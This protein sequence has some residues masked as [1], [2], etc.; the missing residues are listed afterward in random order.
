[1]DTIT[2]TDQTP[3]G[4][5]VTGEGPPLVLVHGGTAD[6]TRWRNTLSLLEPHATV[7]AIDRR[8]R[9]SSGDSHDYSLEKEFADVAAVV[10]QASARAGGPVGLLGHSYGAICALG[11]ARL[12]GGSLRRLVLYEPPIGPAGVV[13]EPDLIERLEAMLADGRREEALETFFREEVQVPPEGIEMLRGLPSWQGR[14][15]AVHTIPRELRAVVNLDPSPQWFTAVTAPTLL[16]LGGDSPKLMRQGTEFVHSH[17]PDSR[18]AE[19]PGQQHLAMDT[20][21]ELF[22]ELVL[23]FLAGKEG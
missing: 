14:V 4:V 18:I 21:P 15:A 1:M 11:G 23:D 3:I 9:G 13:L 7:Y 5:Q 16:L 19:M 8:G 17:L 2:S 6:R 20:A 22:S 12:A 10:A